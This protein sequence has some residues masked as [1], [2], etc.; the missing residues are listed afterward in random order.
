M[1][2]QVRDIMTRPVITAQVGMTLRELM[3]LLREHRISGVPVTDEELKVVGIISEADLIRLDLPADAEPVDSFS[4]RDGMMEVDRS[5]TIEQL[6]RAVEDV[7]TSHIVTCEPSTSVEEACR[8]FRQHHI[9]RLVVMEHGE[10]AGILTPVDVVDAIA[11][12]T[13][14]LAR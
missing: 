6:D 11:A 12:G 9:H 13:V 4:L 7:M 10:I 2:A 14:T 8:L 3:D 5:Y 1:N